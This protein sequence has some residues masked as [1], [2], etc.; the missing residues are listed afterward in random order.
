M[1]ELWSLGRRLKSALKSCG[2]RVDLHGPRPQVVGGQTSDLQVGGALWKILEGYP[3][4]VLL[5]EV[6][7]SH[8]Q[9]HQFD[10]SLCTIAGV[11]L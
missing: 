6:V 5:C 4:E 2:I 1:N 3:R 7:D 11:L 9:S 10:M 8:Q